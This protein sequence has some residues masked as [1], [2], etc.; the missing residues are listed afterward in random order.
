MNFLEIFLTGVGLSMDAFAVSVCRGLSMKKINYKHAL[1]IALMFGGF[2][3]LM[4]LIGWTLGKAFEGYISAFSP[5][6]AF[7]LL[8]YIGGKMLYDGIKGGEGEEALN[9]GSLDMKQLFMMAIAT[10]IDALAVGVSFGV[11]GVNIWSSI[12]IIGVTTFVIAFLGVLI[13]HKFG[14]KYNKGATIA[15][16]AILICIGLKILIESFF[17]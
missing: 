4:P 1:I 5:W 7:I 2:Q 17:A 12:S 10:S 15:G 14:E 9:D 11:T 16:G 6:I 8:A 3:A 13:G